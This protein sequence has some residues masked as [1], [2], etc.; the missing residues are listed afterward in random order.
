MRHEEMSTAPK[1]NHGFN[2]IGEKSILLS[3]IPMFMA[4]HQAQLFLEVTLSAPDGS[5]PV[6][7]YKADKKKTGATAYVLVTDPLTLATLAP[8]APEPLKTFTGKLY[9]G[10]WPFDDMP[11]AP[12]VIPQ[13]TVTVNRSIFFKSL[14]GATALSTLSYYLFRTHESAYVAHVLTVPPT[15]FN[16]LLTV[17]ASGPGADAGQGAVELQFPGVP[18]AIAN[19]LKPKQKA[20]AVVAPGGQQVK[21]QVG[22]EVIYED[23][24]KHLGE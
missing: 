2:L 22:S 17:K 18:N 15:D 5:D 8:G 11:N 9:R 7:T 10:A 14:V 16:Q 19:K 12:V 3:H 20:T 4:P 24:P 13:L 1:F 6:K 23:N 21:L